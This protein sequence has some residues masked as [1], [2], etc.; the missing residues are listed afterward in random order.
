MKTLLLILLIAFAASATIK[1]ENGD[2]QIIVDKAEKP[3]DI[4]D[5][6][7]K[8]SEKA[9]KLLQWL[10]DK[11]YLSSIYYY[12]KQKAIPAAI[13]FCAKKTGFRDVCSNLINQLIPI[14][15]EIESKYKF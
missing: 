11:N 4:K 9:K 6:L 3:I 12:V 15:K 10:V 2:L 1:F 8:L 13:D 5:F 14:F 7:S